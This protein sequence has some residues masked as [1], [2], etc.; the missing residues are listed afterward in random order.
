[1][2]VAENI[3][4]LELGTVNPVLAWDKDEVVLFDACYP[5]QTEELAAAI[6]KLGFS[7]SQITTLILSHQDLDHIGCARD[8]L[9]AA[10][11]LKIIAH[12]IEAPFIDG[13]CNSIRTHMTDTKIA[14][15]APEQRER[16]FR[17]RATY[18]AHRVPITQRVKEGDVLPILGGIEVIHT[19]GHTPGHMCL[20]FKAHKAVFTGDAFGDFAQGPHPTHTLDREQALESVAKVQKYDIEKIWCFHGGAIDKPVSEIFAD[21]AAQAQQRTFDA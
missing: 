4:V 8:V 21:I 12:E 3:E 14:E 1:M 2:R 20:Y 11:N 18:A 9:E 16:Y 7:L 17:S 13:T 15:L 5:G 10:P 19:P 6:E